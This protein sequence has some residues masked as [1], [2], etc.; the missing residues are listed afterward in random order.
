[1]KVFSSLDDVRAAAERIRSYIHKTPVMTCSSIDDLIGGR[2][3]FKCE[4]FQ[5][6]G[7]FKFR[8]ASNAVFSLT[9]KECGKGVA[10]HSSG[11]HAAA[12]S[13]AAQIRG[14]KAIIVMPTTAPS[15]KKAAVERCGAQ[16]V[17][18]EPTQKAR[19][20][21]LDHIA[22]ETGATV[23]HPY[24]DERV[25]AGQGTAALELTSE[26]PDLDIITAPVSGGGLLSGTAIAAKETHPRISV[27]GTEPAGA[28][29]AH[30]SLKLGKIVLCEHPQTIAD[31]LR[32]SLGEKTFPIIQKYVD[33][34]LT[35][36]EEGIIQ[37]MKLVWERMKI[38]IEP[39]AA[40]PVAALF[41]HKAIFSGKRI[42][43]ILSGGNVD[44]D[45]LPWSK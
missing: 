45:H 8:G 42:G 9:D 29:D 5:K 23:V 38:V 43:V 18:C 2:I 32:M 1:M 24:N 22:R 31:G 4:N 15:V 7:A 28:D 39:S 41:E 40:V 33:D 17:L 34:I 12:L 16:I 20:D 25:I 27:L 14:I 13:R 44:L 19:Q 36:S 10:T 21:T 30:R 6:M 26:I 37:G 35:V 3:F 11:N